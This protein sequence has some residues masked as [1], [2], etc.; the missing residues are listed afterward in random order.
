MFSGGQEQQLATAR[1]LYKDSEIYILDEPTAALSPNSEYA[2]YQQFHRISRDKTV[3]F[4]S[5]RLASCTLC[6]EVVVL[7]E[8]KIVEKGRHSDL[9]QKSGLYAEMF[10][11]Q[12]SLY[13]DEI[14]ET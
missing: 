10:E 2:L 4:I 14:Q 8:G 11:K 5:H 3:I 1:A 13:Q 9:I 6:D 7:D 12:A